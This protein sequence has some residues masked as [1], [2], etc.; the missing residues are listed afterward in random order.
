MGSSDASEK[1][2]PPGK[3]IADETT[4]VHSNSQSQSD[5][6]RSSSA[7]GS[8]KSSGVGHKRGEVNVTYLYSFVDAF[9]TEEFKQKFNWKKLKAEQF[10]QWIADTGGSA[11]APES[12]RTLFAISEEKRKR[13]NERVEAD[14]AKNVKK[15]NPARKLASV[16]EVLCTQQVRQIL[17]ASQAVNAYAEKDPRVLEMFNVLFRDKEAAAKFLVGTMYLP[18]VLGAVRGQNRKLNLQTPKKFE[19]LL[20]FHSISVFIAAKMTYSGVM[21]NRIGYAV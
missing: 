10:C 13:H 1:T 5:M 3:L 4:D 14:A 8:S 6:G 17:R 12:V 7:P 19:A 21:G 9:R 16:V 2:S 20:Y 15:K 11:N 18:S